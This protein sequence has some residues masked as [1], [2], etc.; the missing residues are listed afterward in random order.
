M[1]EAFE[2]HVESARWHYDQ[3]TDLFAN[4]PLNHV[5][6]HVDYKEKAKMPLGPEEPGRWWFSTARREVTCVGAHVMQHDEGSTAE[7][8]RILYYVQPNS[9]CKLLS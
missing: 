1:A 4:L 3:L 9:N 7:Q 6:I 8:P 5:A 2:D